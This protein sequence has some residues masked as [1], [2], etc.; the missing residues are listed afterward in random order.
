MAE[1]KNLQHLLRYFTPTRCTTNAGHDYNVLLVNGFIREIINKRHAPNVLVNLC[2]NYYY[3]NYHCQTFTKVFKMK[4]YSNYIIHSYQFPNI[5]SMQ[6]NITQ[7]KKQNIVAVYGLL[8]KN[9]AELLLKHQSFTNAVKS[10]PNIVNKFLVLYIDFE[11]AFS[12]MFNNQNIKY[13][14]LKLLAFYFDKQ[15]FESILMKSQFAVDE[16]KSQMASQ[17]LKANNFILNFEN[18]FYP[19]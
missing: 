4:G 10:H 3:T 1:H 19:C 2:L 15:S 17:T 13:H 7:N 5:Q 9:A 8:N 6:F 18:R 16:S 12:K 11:N 14:D